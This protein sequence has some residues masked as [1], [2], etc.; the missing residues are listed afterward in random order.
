M[1]TPSVL[2]ICK[3]ADGRGVTGVFVEIGLGVEVAGGKNI[4]VLVGLAITVGVFVAGIVDMGVLVFG[5]ILVDMPAGEGVRVGNEAPGVRKTL[6]QAGLVRMAG[7]SGSMKLTGRLVR[8]SLLGSRFDP[9]LVFSLQLG[10]KRIAHPL[11]RMIQK[12][13]NNRI[14]MIRMPESRLSFSR[15]V[16]ETSIDRKADVDCGARV[17]LFVVTRTLQPDTSAMCLDNAARDGE[18]QPGTA[19]FEFGLSRGM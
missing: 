4:C 8:K 2:V 15:V 18:S 14:R 10:A 1:V 19:A 11:A 5:G 17:G 6:S 13:P 7:S 3:S 9:I 16:M 12:N